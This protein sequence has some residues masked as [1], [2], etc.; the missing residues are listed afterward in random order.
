MG[1]CVFIAHH[2][3][4]V[5]ERNMCSQYRLLFVD[6]AAIVCYLLVLLCW[7]CVASSVAQFAFTIFIDYDTLLEFATLDQVHHVARLALLV[8]D[9]LLVEMNGL[10]KVVVLCEHMGAFVLKLVTTHNEVDFLAND[11]LL[12]QGYGL[13]KTLLG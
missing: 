5:Q 13:L 7:P 10:P 11:A 2:H 9:L 1:N 12:N 4:L 3:T 8:N 6:L